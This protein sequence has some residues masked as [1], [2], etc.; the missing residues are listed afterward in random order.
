MIL[1][2]NGVADASGLP[3][4]ELFRRTYAWQVPVVGERLRSIDIAP[5]LAAVRSITSDISLPGGVVSGPED[6]LL[7]ISSRT[8][9]TSN[10][11]VVPVGAL[12]VLFFGVAVL[13]GLGGR[14][15]HQRTASLLRRR[16]ATRRV[17]ACFRLLEAALP[18]VGGR[19]SGG[20]RSVARWMVRPSRRTRWS[21]HPAAIH[22]W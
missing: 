14:A 13:A 1:I 5:M 9:I 22:R 4:Y 21:E 16:G 11:L 2:A 3:D 10:R 19:S 7:S 12:L 20:D 15:D 8:R 6:D 18:V 17:I